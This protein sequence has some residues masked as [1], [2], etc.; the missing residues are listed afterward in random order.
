MFCARRKE[1]REKGV[2]SLLAAFMG[3]DGERDALD[4]W[5]GGRGRP[6]G[7]VDSPKTKPAGIMHAM[8]PAGDALK[9]R[10]HIMVNNGEWRT[11]EAAI[12]IS[13][14]RR[15]GAPLARTA[16]TGLIGLI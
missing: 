16:L 12:I 3:E 11:A 5:C 4:S 6:S 9:S 10:V 2:D 13:A 8:C 14:I 7:G 1:G 15:C